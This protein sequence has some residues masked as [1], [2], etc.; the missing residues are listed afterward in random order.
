MDDHDQL[1]FFFFFIL[2][3]F[4]GVVSNPGKGVGAR[5][6][7]MLNRMERGSLLY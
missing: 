1:N 3:Y 6:F 7:A 4:F 2:F 5:E